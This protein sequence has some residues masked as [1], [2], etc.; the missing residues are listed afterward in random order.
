[1]V[2]AF[3]PDDGPARLFRYVEP[4][5]LPGANLLAIYVKHQ[6]LLII[7]RELFNQ[8]TDTER[9]LVLR[10]QEP[11]LEVEHTRDRSARLAA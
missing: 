6:N 2:F 1:M 8:L 5:T 9:H 3:N 4:G 10:T 7:D 11:S